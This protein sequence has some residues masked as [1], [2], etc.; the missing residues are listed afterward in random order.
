[1]HSKQWDKRRMRSSGVGWDTC[2]RIWFLA[3]SATS[4]SWASANISFNCAYPCTYQRISATRGS[5]AA[6]PSHLH[7]LLQ[8]LD[9][10]SMCKLL[11]LSTK[12]SQ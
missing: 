6:N 5:R 7:Q 12:A 2:N 4:L 1:M 11:V 8:A 9:V 3:S 10:S